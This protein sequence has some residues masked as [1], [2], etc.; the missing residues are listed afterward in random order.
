MF[1][2]PLLC[3]LKAS[4]GMYFLLV[5]SVLPQYLLKVLL[6][7]NPLKHIE[8]AT[9]SR[10]SNLA[11]A[12]GERPQ[13]IA[14][15]HQDHL[16]V[17]PDSQI[18]SEVFLFSFMKLEKEKK[19]IL[20]LFLFKLGYKSLKQGY[21]CNDGEHHSVAQSFLTIHNL[22]LQGGHEI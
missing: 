5:S 17:G 3:P 7:L 19:K 2:P 18:S 9:K 1:Y 15:T 12:K 14:Q 11:T 8:I 6:T 21:K 20:Y 22:K 10:I 13:K 16:Q 4:I